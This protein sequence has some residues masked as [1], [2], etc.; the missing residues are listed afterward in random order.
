MNA[1]VKKYRLRYDY[2]AL[3]A[4]VDKKQGTKDAWKVDWRAMKLPYYGVYVI[5]TKEE[6]PCK[7]G[8]SKCAKDRLAA[9]QTSHWQKLVVN[10]Y[11]WVADSKA[12]Y[13]IE[14][15]SHEI[16]KERGKGLLGE[17]FD[18]S[19]AEAIEALEWSSLVLGLELNEQMPPNVL[20]AMRKK[21]AAHLTLRM[22]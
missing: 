21:R 20:R 10:G 6:R 2:D 8:V 13:A 12:A 4:E 18:V 1:P 9:L 11:R 5:G 16:L 22:G 3:V 7:I 15:K 17:W 14:R 19:T